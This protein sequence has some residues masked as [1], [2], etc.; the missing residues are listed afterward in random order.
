MKQGIYISWEKEEILM[1]KKKIKKSVI[2]RY[3][4]YYLML[5]PALAYIIVNNYIPM[6]GVFIAFKKINFVKGIFA[7]PWCGFDNFKFLFKTKDAWLMTKNTLLYN[8]AFIVVGTVMAII[9]AI[10]LSE[11]KNAHYQKAVQ[12]CLTIP[13]L[14]SMVIVS[15]LVYGFLSTDNGFI[16]NT[17]LPLFGKAPVSWYTEKA[18][19]PFIFVFIN[20][21]KGIGMSSILY[22]STIIGIDSVLYESA[23][24]DG[25]TKLQQIRY[26]TLPMIKPTVILLTLMSI[27]KILNSDFGL[28]YQVPMNSGPLYSV[29]TTIDTYV[30]KGLMVDG[31][32]SLSSAANFYQSM[33]GFVLVLLSNWI[34]KKVDKESALF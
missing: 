32:M 22:L 17:I 19:W 23:S 7:S 1:G 5:L 3:A 29:T 18:P 2:K 6:A 11:V 10:M 24:L 20:L 31:N 12:T 26:I 15:Y 4:I 14:I 8:L 30:Y 34:V 21:W 9:V 16:N 28:F 33:V 25:A 27:G 13:A